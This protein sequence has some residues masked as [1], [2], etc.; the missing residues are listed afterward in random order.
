[1]KQT[2]E[3][4]VNEY[5]YD[6]ERMDEDFG[7]GEDSTARRLASLDERIYNNLDCTDCPDVEYYEDPKDL[8]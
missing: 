6:D 2:P 1:V 8:L 5:L 7:T 4:V 3:E